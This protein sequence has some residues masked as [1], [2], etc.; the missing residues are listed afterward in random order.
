MK[1]ATKRIILI[2][3][4]LILLI[5]TFAGVTASASYNDQVDFTANIVLLESLDSGAVIFDKNAD[6]KT[7][8]ASLTKITTAMV[9]LENCDDLNAVVTAKQSIIRS[10]D[11][12]DSSTAGIAVGEQ[13]TV[14]QLLQCLLVKSANEAAVILADYVG[15]STDNFVKMM[16]DYVKKLG[17]THTH[18][19]NPHGL[20]ADGHYT[21]ASDLAIIVKHALK[22]KTFVELVNTLTINLPA[23]QYREKAVS[24]NTTNYLIS[25]HSRYYYEYAA[26]VKTGTTENA[27]HCLISTAT[28]NGYTYLCI[29][30]QDKSTDTNGD[31][32][33]ENLAFTESKKA[34]KWAFTNIKL[35]VV[36]ETTDIITDVSVKLGKKTDHV[37]LVPAQQVTALVPYNIDSSAILVQPVKDSISDNIMAPIKKGDKLGKAEIIYAG[38]VIGTVD[39]VAAN[40]VKRSFFAYFGY[41]IKKAF[42]ST[43]GIII[44]ALLII[45]VA[46][47]FIFRYVYNSR[48]RKKRIKVVKN[49]RNI[50]KK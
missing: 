9:V 6:L 13:L 41:L 31:G 5:S 2:F 39:L 44:I 47:F 27:G 7:A 43:V 11:G 23:N 45:L 38:D 34:Y 1:K 20:D 25:P 26:G 29:I 8:P 21:T 19:V 32:L 46:G 14:Y 4:S 3:L 33:E 18:Y 24:Y 49:Y 17:C 37:Q 40:D 28:K 30:L 22:N 42:T 10:L 35:K 36:A 50:N 12:T 15:G 16:N 48:K